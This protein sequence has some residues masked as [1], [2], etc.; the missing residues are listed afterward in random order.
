MAAVADYVLSMS[1]VNDSAFPFWIA[2]EILW[3]RYIVSLGSSVSIAERRSISSI[4]STICASQNPVVTMKTGLKIRV[5]LSSGYL[6]IFDLAACLTEL[7]ASTDV[8]CVCDVAYVSGTV[9][10][11]ANVLPLDHG[12]SVTQSG[13]L[14]F[15]R[16]RP[17]DSLWAGTLVRFTALQMTSLSTEWR[18]CRATDLLQDR[19]W[20]PLASTGLPH[21]HV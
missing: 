1:N 10:S 13:F 5:A 15:C 11:H 2:T 3:N 4:N 9:T 12:R 19:P 18:W 14:P 16:T 20:R 7:R 6:E 8:A 17:V 21:T